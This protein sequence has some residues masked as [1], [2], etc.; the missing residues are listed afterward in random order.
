MFILNVRTNTAAKYI[1]SNVHYS[2]FQDIYAAR[3]EGL[4]K[5]TSVQPKSMKG[6]MSKI[7]SLTHYFL[8]ENKNTGTITDF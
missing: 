4:K 6:K 2:L 3:L 1:T 8:L 7:S 5:N